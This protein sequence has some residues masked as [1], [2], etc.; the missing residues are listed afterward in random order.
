[1]LQTTFQVHLDCNSLWNHVIW[2]LGSK[3]K[4]RPPTRPHRLI[5][6]E[7]IPF[8]ISFGLKLLMRSAVLHRPLRF[9]VQSSVCLSC[10]SLEK[11]SEIYSDALLCYNCVQ[12]RWRVRLNRLEHEK[13]G[14]FLRSYSFKARYKCITLQGLLARKV[15]GKPKVENHR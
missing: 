13:R 1:M 10:C 8:P 12:L 15:P 3:P 11:V 2:M 5:L 4:G 6:L 14:P 9:Q 7:Q